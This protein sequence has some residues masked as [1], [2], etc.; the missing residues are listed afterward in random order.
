M[1]KR[2]EKHYGD[3]QD[4]E[5]TIQEGKLYMLQTRNG[6]RTGMAAVK[7]AVD[8][9][10]EGLITREQALLKVEPEALNQ[11]LHPIFDL[12]E[13]AKHTVLAKGLAASPGAATGQ[14]VFTANEAVAWAK[15]GKKVI[16]V[17]EET[18]PTTS[19]A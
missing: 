16:L 6:K 11:L 9:V 7:I 8:L 4:F 5:F 1:V 13:K 12:Q 3:V 14:I 17:R 19:T 15:E 2:L 10:E 18:S